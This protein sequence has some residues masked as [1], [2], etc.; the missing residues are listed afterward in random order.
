M[1][2]TGYG[3][4]EDRKAVIEAGFNEHLVKPA[5]VTDVEAILRRIKQ[6][7]PNASSKTLPSAE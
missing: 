3:R 7:V 4:P 5:T 2:L 1:A 6:S